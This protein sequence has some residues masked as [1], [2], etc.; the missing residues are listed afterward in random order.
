MINLAIVD[1]H[2]AIRSGIRKI[3]EECGDVFISMEASNGQD[4]LKKLAVAQAPDIAIIDINMPVMNGHELVKKLQA[5]FPQVRPIVYSIVCGIDAMV[6]MFTSGASA[7]LN[8][9]KDITEL[10]TAIRAVYEKGSYLSNIQIP[11]LVKPRQNGMKPG[12]FGRS[13]LTPRET[14]VINMLATDLNYHQI[15]DRLK[16]GEKTI[17]NYRD[18]IYQKLG[19]R[20]RSELTLFAIN[21]GLTYSITNIT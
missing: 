16:V 6:H 17:H 5:D 13:Y 9:A 7:Y 10:P 3:L 19:I 21:N 11:A 8:K 4:F 2:P 20:N 14:V 18:R 15:G 1:D 12:F